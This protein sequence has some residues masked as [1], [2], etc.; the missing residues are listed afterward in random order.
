MFYL[1][2]GASQL[3]VMPLAALLL[4]A[5]ASPAL[6]SCPAGW[7]VELST[8]LGDGPYCR[9]MSSQRAYPMGGFKDLTKLP[10]GYDL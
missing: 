4:L 8:V 9:K 5:A 2:S 10:F 3:T 7:L 1:P 6:A